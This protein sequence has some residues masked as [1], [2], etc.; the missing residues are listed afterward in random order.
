LIDLDERDFSPENCE[1]RDY[2]FNGRT[3]NFSNPAGVEYI[4]NPGGCDSLYT[5]N[6]IERTAEETFLDIDLCMDMDTVVNGVTYNANNS[7]GSSPLQTVFGCDSVVYISLFIGAPQVDYT[8]SICPGD[9]RGILLDANAA[10][11][12]NIGS[13]PLQDNNFQLAVTSTAMITTYDWSPA[14]IL[15]CDDCPDPIATIS[16]ETF[17][18]VQVTSSEGCSY[19]SS[20]TLVP[21]DTPAVTDTITKVYIP[22]SINPEDPSNNKF[23]VMSNNDNLMIKEMAIY[24]RWGNLVFIEKD[25]PANDPNFGWDARKDNRD[26]QQGVYVYL[27]K[28]ETPVLGSTLESGDL[29]IIR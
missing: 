20:I 11:D 13:V 6:I 7:M 10:P 24:D 27:I 12:L 26:I 17:V 23:Y 19:E 2:I 22:N 29:T 16:E 1:D 25:F 4:D 8:T 5:I 18:T 28:F 3:Y 9:T 14:G 21:D 15:S